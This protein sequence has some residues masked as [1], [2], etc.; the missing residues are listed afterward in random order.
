MTAQTLLFIHCGGINHTNCDKFIEILIRFIQG[1]AGSQN[2]FQYMK[3]LCQLT[4]VKF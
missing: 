1:P 2:V 3:M 4:K